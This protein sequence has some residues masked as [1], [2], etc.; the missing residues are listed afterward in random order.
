[1]VADDVLDGD[2]VEDVLG[3]LVLVEEHERAGA[4]DGGHVHDVVAAL[5][6]E[7]GL[8]GFDL[9]KGEGGAFVGTELG[10][11]VGV[12]EE[13]EAEIAGA[14]GGR[15]LGDGRNGCCGGGCGGEGEEAAAVEAV[16]G[17]MVQEG[18]CVQARRIWAE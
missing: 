17:W 2:A 11:V 4:G 7:V 3:L 18:C 6:A 12:G 8:E 5:D 13:D 15:G 1:M 14:G 9:C 10:L 16:M